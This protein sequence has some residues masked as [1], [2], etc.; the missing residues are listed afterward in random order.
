M[1]SYSKSVREREPVALS[2]S[3]MIIIM[4]KEEEEEVSTFR[5]VQFRERPFFFAEFDAFLSNSLLFDVYSL[6]ISAFN[7]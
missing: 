6:A 2:M 4:I 7:A 5:L 3:M 1:G